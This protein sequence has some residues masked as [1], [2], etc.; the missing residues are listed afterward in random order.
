M[1]EDDNVIITL[2]GKMVANP[3]YEFVFVGESSECRTCR[4]KN[5]C[6]NLTKGSRYRVVGVRDAPVHECPLHEEGI[7]AVEVVEVPQKVAIESRKAFEGSKIV[8]SVI[9]CNEIT[10]PNYG[11]CHPEGF[12]EGD[13]AA[14]VRVLEPIKCKKGYSLK[15]VELRQ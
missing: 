1:M 15:V 2:I 5:S 14:I 12:E 9:E 7:Q 4:L 13:K 3:G 6:M 10:C 8:Y 11:L